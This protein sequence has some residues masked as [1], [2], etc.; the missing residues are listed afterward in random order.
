MYVCMSGSD[1]KDFEE[2]VRKSGRIRKE[3][4]NC[5]AFFPFEKKN[6]SLVII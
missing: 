6:G 3:K 1:R 2:T 4:E 5:N